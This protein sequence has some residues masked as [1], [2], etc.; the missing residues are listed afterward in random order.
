MY[1]GILG[2]DEEIDSLIDKIGSK[3]SS[4]SEYICELVELKG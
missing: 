1:Y 3:L 4:E 2:L